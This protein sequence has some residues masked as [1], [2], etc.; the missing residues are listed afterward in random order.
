MAD[1]A[2]PRADTLRLRVLSA[3]VLIPLAL[4]AVWFG[5]PW[6]TVIV[7]AAGLAMGWEWGRLSGSGQFGPREIVIVASIILAIG[8]AA[9]GRFDLGLTLAVLG[10]AAAGWAGRAERSW[11]A[12]GTV[13][14]ACGCA[15]FLWLDRPAQG[16]KAAIFWLLGVVWATDIVAYIAGRTI[17]GPRLAPRISPNKTWSGVAGGLIGG[18]AVGLAAAGLADRRAA[19]LIALSLAVSLFAQGGDLAESAAKRHYAVKDTS[20]LI[21]GHGGVLDR[22]DGLLAAAIVAALL[23]LMLGGGALNLD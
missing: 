12:L 3:L 23:T 4:A 22:L 16:G 19:P 7:A 10:A 11:T 2:A 8:A 17:G 13:W 21:P 5:P 9:A 1:G 14:I 15:A 18:G 20:H 6:V